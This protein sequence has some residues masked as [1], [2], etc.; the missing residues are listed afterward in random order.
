MKKIVLY[1]FLVVL[2]FITGCSDKDKI[3]NNNLNDDFTYLINEKIG[4]DSWEWGRGIAKIP[5]GGYIV[6]GWTDSYGVGRNDLYLIN[7]S[8][9]GEVVW[10]KNFGGNMNNSDDYGESVIITGGS[11][12]LAVGGSNSFAAQYQFYLIKTDF[13]GQLLWD[14]TYSAMTYESRSK[15]FEISDGYIIGGNTGTS[16]DER[17]YVFKINFSGDFLWDST[18]QNSSRAEFHCM[19]KTTDNGFVIGGSYFLKIDADGKTV[20]KN[21]TYLSPDPEVNEIINAVIETANGDLIAVGGQSTPSTQYQDPYS[22][23]VIKLSSEGTVLWQHQYDFA[24]NA[25]GTQVVENNDGTVSVLMTEPLN[26][27]LMLVKLDESDG[28]LQDTLDASV[29]GIPFDM[30]AGHNGY[31]FT[32]YTSESD[33][34][35]TTDA[36]SVLVVEMVE[37]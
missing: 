18:Y 26:N 2:L 22:L 16:L 32:G 8:N 27:D 7:I 23:Y 21:N 6:T 11:N 33:S 24:V 31:F 12:I 13:N 25:L 10:E 36:G 34:D 9:T 37:K 30:I 29:T 14:T 3:T 15:V 20:W 35:S 28:S 1:N 17:Y 5:S 4:G 19:T